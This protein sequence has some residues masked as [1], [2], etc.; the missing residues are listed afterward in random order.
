[1]IISYYNFPK[2][3][4]TSS[5]ALF[6]LT[7]VAKAQRS[8]KILTSNIAF[9]LDNLFKCNFFLIDCFRPSSEHNFNYYCT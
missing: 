1:M 5:N 4:V 8:S 7:N 3:K 9:L 2:S 6:C